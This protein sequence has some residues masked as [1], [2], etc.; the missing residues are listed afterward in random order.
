METPIPFTLT[1][2]ITTLDLAG[3]AAVII[4]AGFRPNYDWIDFPVFD[5][6]GYPVTT[7][8]AVTS[9]PGLYF[10]GVHFMLR[11]R[12]GFLFGV[13][14]DAETVAELIARR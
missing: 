7:D 4:A 12:S 10:C 2:P 14:D 8:G 3:F 1:D 11:R 5:E 13:G 9:V 6:I